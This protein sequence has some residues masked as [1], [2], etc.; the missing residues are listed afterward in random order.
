V[1]K[2]TLRVL[3]LVKHLYRKPLLIAPM[4]KTLSNKKVS[5]YRG[6]TMTPKPNSFRALDVKHP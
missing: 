3:G 6:I 2:L 4:E 5:F 1:I